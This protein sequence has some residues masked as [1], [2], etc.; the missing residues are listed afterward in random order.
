MLACLQLSLMRAS[1]RTPHRSNKNLGYDIGYPKKLDQLHYVTS[2]NAT[3]TNDIAQ[4]AREEF[5]SLAYQSNDNMVSADLV[6]VRGSSFVIGARE[7]TRIF[8]PILDVLKE[9]EPSRRGGMKILVP[10]CG[11]GRLAWEIAQFGIY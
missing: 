11:L 1:Y 6:R 7:R 8:S 9:V 5:P 3:I 10:G 4:L 2:L